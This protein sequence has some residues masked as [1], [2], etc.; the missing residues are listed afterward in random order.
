MG[1]RLFHTGVRPKRSRKRERGTSAVEFA[2]VIPVF[3]LV[4]VGVGELTR[5]VWIYGTVAYAAREG[6]RYAMV[7]GAENKDPATAADIESYVQAKAG[8]GSLTEVTTT[9]APDN[10]PG[11]IV[12]VNVQYDFQSV[13][14]MLPIGPIALRSSS[15]MVIA[16]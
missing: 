3:L 6:T 1:I 8:Y 12:E 14:S 9:W 4:I 16:H 15:R 11:S 10:K 7:R 2:L 13:A 5:A